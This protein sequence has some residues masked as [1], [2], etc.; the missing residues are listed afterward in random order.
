MIPITFPLLRTD[1]I[2]QRTVGRAGITTRTALDTVGDIILLG[3]IPF[4]KFCCIHQQGR[5]E[6]IGQTLTHLAQ[7]IQSRIGLRTDSSLSGAIR[8][9]YLCYRYLSN[10]GFSHHRAATDYLPVF[11][12]TP[13]AASISA[14]IG[15]PIRLQE[16]GRIGNCFTCHG[17]DAFKQRFVFITASY[18]AK[19]V[20][21]FCTT[22]WRK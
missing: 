21:T 19:A 13:P 20:P 9:N 4:C 17:N 12:G 11:S 6:A 10:Q 1:I 22:A 18:T 14:L 2:Q 7:R 16:V 5:V 3:Q 8:L 15:V